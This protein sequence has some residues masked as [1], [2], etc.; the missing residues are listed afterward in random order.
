MFLVSAQCGDFLS[1]ISTD[2]YKPSLYQSTLCL[3][4]NSWSVSVWAFKTGLRC[5]RLREDQRR[6]ER[7][8]GVA[9]RYLY[10]GFTLLFSFSSIN[11]KIRELNSQGAL[12][13][14][15]FGARGAQTGIQASGVWLL[16]QAKMLGSALNLHVSGGHARSDARLRMLTPERLCVNWQC[17]V[18][19]LWYTRCEISG[20]VRMCSG[21][22]AFRVRNSDGR[23]S[24][25][26]RPSVSNPST[27]HWT[28][29]GSSDHV[30]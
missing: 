13:M 6:S 26:F 9:L 5:T 24:W 8:S 19:T 17:Q 15:T 18:H 10:F 30:R 16:I 2:V 7:S 28:P 27:F 4:W 20:S 29:S 12:S 23:V 25:R 11:V 21:S 22:D 3:S 1:A 14:P